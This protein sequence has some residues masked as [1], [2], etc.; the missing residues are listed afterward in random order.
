VSLQV[1]C[2]P[3][4]C[5]VNTDGMRGW[6][7]SRPLIMCW[8]RS[9][10]C[11]AGRSESLTWPCAKPRRKFGDEWWMIHKGWLLI[12]RLNA[13]AGGVT[14]G[15]DHIPVG[16]CGV[17][18]PSRRLAKPCRG[19]NARCL[20]RVFQIDRSTSKPLITLIFTSDGDNHYTVP[21]GMTAACSAPLLIR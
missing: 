7:H 13:P 9:R 14:G 17:R 3:L 20:W 5:D 15:D 8:I 4:S 10:F 1:R 6:P 11:V 19:W 16:S 2:T 12:R 18:R 21:L